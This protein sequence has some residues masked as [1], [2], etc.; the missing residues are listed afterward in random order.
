MHDSVRYLQNRLPD[1]TDILHEYFIPRAAFTAYVD[2]MWTLL[3]RHQAT[4]LNASVRAVHQED[5]FLNYAP[6]EMFSL[7]LYLNQPTSPAGNERMRALTSDLIDLTVQ[8]GGGGFSCPTSYTT[9][10]GN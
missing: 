9:L 1:E 7:E 10:P 2:G 3:Q 6:A 4:L 5:N 8:S